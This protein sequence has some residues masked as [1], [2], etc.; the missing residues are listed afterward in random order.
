MP[1]RQATYFLL[2][3]RHH[4]FVPFLPN[5]VK[6]IK[7][8]LEQGA[9]GFLHWQLVVA[10]ESKKTLVAIKEIF[11]D[12]AHIEFTR[13]KAANSYVWKDETAIPNT[14]FDLGKLP[15]NPASATDWENVWEVQVYEYYDWPTIE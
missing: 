14:R 2:T 12:S 3:I 8:Q 6:Y 15:I 13:S 4:D 11:G 9:G 5:G 1:S 7:G 10:T